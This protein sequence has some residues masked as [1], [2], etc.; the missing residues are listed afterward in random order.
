MEL[1]LIPYF[2]IIFPNKNKR[3]LFRQRGPINIVYYMNFFYWKIYNFQKELERSYFV[4]MITKI[5][6]K[7]ISTK[8][9]NVE[10]MPIRHFRVQQLAFFEE[11][12]F[13][14]FLSTTW[15][16]AWFFLEKP[17]VLIDILN[18]LHWNGVIFIG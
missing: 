14:F 17:R 15:I 12:T 6:S 7:P 10:R 5:V 8:K 9:Q 16:L 3:S 11:L 2:K 1:Q 18:I 4:A 13:F